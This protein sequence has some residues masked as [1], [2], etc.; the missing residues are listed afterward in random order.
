[1]G[2]GIGGQRGDE[3]VVFW[4]FF[5]TVNVSHVF[6]VGIRTMLRRADITKALPVGPARFLLGETA[7]SLLFAD[8]LRLGVAP[9]Y[10]GAGGGRGPL[11]RVAFLMLP[12]LAAVILLVQT[13]FVLLYPNRADP[14]QNAVG[15]LL[16]ASW[17]RWRW[18]FP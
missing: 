8:G 10:G 17:P 13:C 14:A 2:R 7:F 1:M 16:G 18:G 4:I 12:T 5:Y 15:N 11:F 6:L 9:P 3:A